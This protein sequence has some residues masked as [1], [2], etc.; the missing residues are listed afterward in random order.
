MFELGRIGPLD[1][2]QWRIRLHYSARNKVV[3]PKEILVL[4]KS[5]KVP[6]AKGKG[7]EVLVDDIQ[8]ST[9]R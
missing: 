1:I 5:I 7:S 9:C 3:Q 6:P 8:Q 2:D 4:P